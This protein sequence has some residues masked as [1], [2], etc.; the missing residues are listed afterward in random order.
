MGT[1]VKRM[2]DKLLYLCIG[3]GLAI[4]ATELADSLQE[5]KT[6]LYYLMEPPVSIPFESEGRVFRAIRFG[7][8]GNEAVRDWVVDITFPGTTQIMAFTTDY[9]SGGDGLVKKGPGPQRKLT[10]RGTRDV[11]NPGGSF[12]V[13]YLLAADARP[14]ITFTAAGLTVEERPAV[15]TDIVRGG[16]GWR[17]TIATAFGAGLAFLIISKGFMAVNR[18]RRRKV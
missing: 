12:S 4:C 9:E 1:I 6:G 13:Y 11:L 18:W 8:D 5:R 14:R 7:N 3:A 16:G 10:Y 17:S 2:Q 15:T